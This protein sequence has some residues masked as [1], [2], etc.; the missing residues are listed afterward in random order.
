MPSTG[1]RR[2]GRSGTTAKGPRRR[3]APAES[4]IRKILDAVE[5]VLI[6]DGYHA[7]STRRVAARAGVS[8][9]HLTYYFPT[10]RELTR[11]VITAL[12]SRYD[13]RIR[14]V[15]AVLRARAGGDSRELI[16]WLLR[17][18]VSARTG[19]LFPELWVMAKHD[20]FIARE[21]RR[22]YA[23]LIGTF[24]D[25][26]QALHPGADRRQLLQLGYLV[27]MLT[28]GGTV[29]FASRGKR[30]VTFDDMIDM[31]VDVYAERLH[32]IVGTS[33]TSSWGVSD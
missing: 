5:R 9:G 32:R 16:V 15:P 8:L 30:P 2:T 4:T 21:L 19:G 33:V 24:A 31:L 13:Q 14:S 18:I 17:D 12:M 28:E 27:A 7:L 25:M 22:F 29:L 11:A 1:R 10:K 6:E 23:G 26:V 3:Y 20:R